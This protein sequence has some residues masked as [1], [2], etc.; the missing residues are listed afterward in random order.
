[1]TTPTEYSLEKINNELKLGYHKLVMVTAAALKA[2]HK[3]FVDLIDIEGSKIMAAYQTVY[4]DATK[5]TAN[6][7]SFQLQRRSDVIA[8]RQALKD[9]ATCETLGG[10]GWKKA[11][12]MKVAMRSLTEEKVLDREGEFHGEYSF[13]GD[14]VTKAL[15][16][17]NKMDGDNAANRM[18]L[19]GPGGGPIQQQITGFEVIEYDDDEPDPDDTPDKED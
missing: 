14:W 6:Q 19:S 1:M 11:M 16:E 2:E 15:A 5:V 9:Y 13:R 10:R 7:A 8:Y 3:R 17:L 4:P 12:L 18:E